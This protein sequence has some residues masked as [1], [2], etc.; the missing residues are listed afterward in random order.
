MEITTETKVKSPY[1]TFDRKT[2]TYT[3]KA[4]REFKEGRLTRKYLTAE[5]AIWQVRKYEAAKK[6]LRR[7][8]KFLTF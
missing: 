7:D 5:E 2:G 1:L 4:E 8:E 6:Q 3:F